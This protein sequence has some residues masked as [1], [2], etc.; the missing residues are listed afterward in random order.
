MRRLQCAHDPVTLLW[1]GGGLRRRG[2]DVS[3]EGSRLRVSTGAGLTL[4]F[5]DFVMYRTSHGQMGMYNDHA[6]QVNNF[7][8]TTTNFYDHNALLYFHVFRV[9]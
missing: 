3:A 5:W 9:L 2:T 7:P 6:R 1:A 8:V 4:L